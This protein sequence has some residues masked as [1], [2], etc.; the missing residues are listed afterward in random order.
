MFIVICKFIN[1]SDI[2][3]NLICA[4]K[5]I[6]SFHFNPL[7]LH[8]LLSISFPNEAKI[9]HHVYF[10]VAIGDEVI[11]TV[12]LGLFGEDAPLTV[13]NFA[14]IAN[15]DSQVEKNKMGYN[16]SIFHRVID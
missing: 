8:L 11:G 1:W 3:I 9:T 14:T 2:F 7:M 16:N 15:M 13:K 5:H 10:K 4:N 12:K 6:I